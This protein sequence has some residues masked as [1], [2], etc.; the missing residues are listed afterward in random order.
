MALEFER[1]LQAEL[2]NL[3]LQLEVPENAAKQSDTYKHLKT[4]ICIENIR[5]GA[6]YGVSMRLIANF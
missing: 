5:K 1:L 3:K 6:R 4:S 2:K